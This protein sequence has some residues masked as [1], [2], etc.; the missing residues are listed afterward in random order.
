MGFKTMSH[1]HL[2]AQ[3]TERFAQLPE[4]EAIALGGSQA[5]GQAGAASDYDVYI[6]TRADLPAE[7]RLAIG[8]EFD[9]SAALI[10]FWGPGVEWDDESGMHVDTVYFDAGWMEDQV[11][12]CLTRHQ[13]WMGY[14]TCFWHT[15]R[16]SQVLYDRNGWFEGLHAHAQTPYPQALAQAIVALNHPPLR[17]TFSSYRRQ[18]DKAVRRHDSIS[19]NHRTAGLLASLFDILF[20]INMQTHPGEKRLIEWVEKTCPIR[21]ATLRTDIDALLLAAAVAPDAVLNSADRLIDGLDTV[22]HREGWL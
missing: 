13:A 18:L 11:E 21:P 10:D 16:V 5:T 22:L 19:L 7:T 14:T 2:L 17:T 12:R 4:V 6:Y 20:A 1:P 9:E 15:V 8:R 3:I